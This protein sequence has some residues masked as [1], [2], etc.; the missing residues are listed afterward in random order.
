MT[1]PDT[2]HRGILLAKS[3]LCFDNVETAQKTSLGQIHKHLGATILCHSEFYPQAYCSA[4][5]KKNPVDA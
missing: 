5:N 2:D 3:I 4:W 1:G